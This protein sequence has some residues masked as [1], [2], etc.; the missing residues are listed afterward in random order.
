MNTGLHH[1][2][3]LLFVVKTIKYQLFQA[4]Q[5]NKCP[6]KQ[7]HS[8]SSTVFVPEKKTMVGVNADWYTA[9]D[10]L[11]ESYELQ[12]AHSAMSAL[13][14]CP[15]TETEYAAIMSSFNVASW[16]PSLPPHKH[17]RIEE[18]IR[19]EKSEDGA[20]GKR[21]KQGRRR[22]KMLYKLT[23]LSAYNTWTLSALTVA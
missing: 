5:P 16:V 13:H 10:I 18:S 1:M 14:K 12:R 17:R 9:A 4:V 2:K 22:G 21:R 7:C 15:P 8:W 11:H 3:S 23:V 20:G 6:E 19:R